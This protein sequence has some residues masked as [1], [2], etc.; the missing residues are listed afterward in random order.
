MYIFEKVGV[1][2][3][4][5]PVDKYGTVSVDNIIPNKAETLLVV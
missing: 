1:Q 2:I 4:Y 5:L 3:D